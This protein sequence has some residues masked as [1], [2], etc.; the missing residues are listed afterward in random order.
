MESGGGKMQMGQVRIS[1]NDEE[2]W[3]FR[4]SGGGEVTRQAQV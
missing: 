4:L 2:A 3:G 1:R